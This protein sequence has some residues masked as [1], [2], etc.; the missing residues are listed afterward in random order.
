MILVYGPDELLVRE[1]V[2]DLNQ[3]GQLATAIEPDA[4]VFSEVLVTRATAVVGVLPQK[5]RASE[6]EACE[7]VKA[8]T[9]ASTAPSAPRIVLVTPAP[10]YALHVRMLKRSGAPYVV[11]S[12][13]ALTELPAPAYLP[14]RAVWIARDV[15]SEQHTLA[16]QGALLDAIAAAAN[17]EA[18][19]GVE[20]APERVHW[21]VALRGA[22]ARVRVVPA[23]LARCAALI[24][25]PAVYRDLQGK[26]VVRL[27]YEQIARALGA[28]PSGQ[29]A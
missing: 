19:Q 9:E 2:R 16:T 25:Q 1:V 21:D 27:G 29:P 11:I 22:G 17:D 8:L 14:K 20:Q 5:P 13:E 23:W 26:L 7:F 15:L 12:S 6:D 24:R 3:R 28:L 10:S 4:H 18:A